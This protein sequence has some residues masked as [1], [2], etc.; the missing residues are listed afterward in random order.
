MRCDKQ[1]YLIDRIW[2]AFGAEQ[3]AG[4]ARVAVAGGSVKGRVSVLFVRCVAFV[5]FGADWSGFS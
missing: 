1:T 5:S 4:H 3:N 2:V